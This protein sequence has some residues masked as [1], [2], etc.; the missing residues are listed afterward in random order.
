MVELPNREP[1]KIDYLREDPEVY[2]Q[3]WVCMS[4][5]TPET[6]E[7]PS[8]VRSVK[9][10]GVYGSEA[11]ARARC[12]QIRD[13]DSD[14]NVYIAPVG[15]WLPW[16]DDPEKASDFNYSNEK[17]NDMMKAYYENQAK[18]KDEFEKR[19]NDMVQQSMQDNEKRAKDNDKKE[20]KKKRKKKKKKVVDNEIVDKVEQN[21]QL[22]LEKEQKMLEQKEKE[23]EEAKK[24]IADADDEL[25]KAEELYEKMLREEGEQ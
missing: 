13:F 24:K 16:C 22:E 25:K 1:K 9:V 21:Y 14:F 17:L 10:R 11:E 4:F 23:Y 19:K 5:L 7:M 12:D 2:G 8:D 18:A 20:R 6:I 15:K 3:K